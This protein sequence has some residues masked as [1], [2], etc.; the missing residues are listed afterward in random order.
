MPKVSKS[1]FIPRD[2]KEVFDYLANFENTAR[3]DP[4]VL[5]A[6][7]TSNGPVE[8][9]STFDLVTIFRGRRIEVTYEVTDYQP[10]TRIVLVGTNSRFTGTDDIGVAAEG[11]GTRVSWNAIFRLEGIAKL[12]QPFLRGVFE[13]LSQEAM[14]GLT[15]TLG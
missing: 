9:G 10:N 13:E 11:Q 5:E 15:E 6:V 2:P 3:W 12:F 14:D 8:L 1:V 7:K 4:G